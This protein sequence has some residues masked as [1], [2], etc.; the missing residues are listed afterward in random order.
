LEQLDPSI[1]SGNSQIMSEEGDRSSK[2]LDDLNWAKRTST[3]S[4]MPLRVEKTNIVCDPS[5]SFTRPSKLM[6][7]EE[8]YS[9][10]Q[11]SQVHVT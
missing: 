4:S 9:E 1:S 10:Q 11:S 6:K 3:Y 2:V 5:E 8:G 7:L